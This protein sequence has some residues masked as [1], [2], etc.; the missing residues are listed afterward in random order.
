MLT[1]SRL[2]PVTRALISGRRASCF[3]RCRTGAL[4]RQQ[5]LCQSEKR[6][7]G[8]DDGTRAA[9]SVYDR[10]HLPPISILRAG[11]AVL[12]ICP[13][14]RAVVSP[15]P[16]EISSLFLR[17]RTHIST[18]T[19]G[20]VFCLRSQARKDTR[21]RRCTRE[22]KY[23]FSV[24]FAGMDARK[25][26]NRHYTCTRTHMSLCART[27]VEKSSDVARRRKVEEAM[28]AAMVRSQSTYRVFVC[29]SL[30][31]GTLHGVA[32]VQTICLQRISFI[33]I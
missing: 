7:R 5:Q 17:Q 11:E 1:G 15:P 24:T 26:K 10:F 13:R 32:E 23:G 29:T 31:E 22:S 4:R 18:V 21:Q 2:A 28:T 25:A 9:A 16:R 33:F 6:L 3:S 19:R 12:C 14:S 30:N 27:Q 8:V 20:S